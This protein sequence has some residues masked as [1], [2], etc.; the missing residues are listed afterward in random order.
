MVNLPGGPFGVASVIDGDTIEIHGT[1][2]R[3]HG[4]DAVEAAQLCTKNARALTDPF[5]ST[6]AARRTRR[7]MQRRSI[8]KRTLGTLLFWTWGA[9][10]TIRD[11]VMRQY[12]LKTSPSGGAR[13]PIE[14][15]PVVL[16][17]QGVKPSVYHY[18]PHR[19]TLVM[20]RSG[21]FRSKVSALCANQTW[22]EN[23]SVLFIMT[24]ALDR[25]MWKYRHSHA[26]RVLY[27]DAGHLG[28]TF[29]LVCTHLGLAPFITA[30]LSDSAIETL[31]KI[32]GIKEVPIYVGA[33]GIPVEA[34][35][36]GNMGD[37]A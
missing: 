19:H 2:V 36:V 29:H 34:A 16:G 37:V 20:I 21:D 23:A 6:L 33:A 8:D 32:D 35:S 1:K 26:Y 13:D 31:L 27:L 18:A 3:L 5:W 10:K 22:V 12:M 9:A 11:P 14:V 15:Y 28:Q 25:S 17:V 4:I 30:A 24:A 7:S